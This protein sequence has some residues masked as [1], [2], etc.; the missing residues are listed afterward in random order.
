MVKERM[1]MGWGYGEDGERGV[2]SWEVERLR[3]S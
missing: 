2:G 3:C 1:W